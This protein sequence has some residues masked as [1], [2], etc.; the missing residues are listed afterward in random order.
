[1]T[2]GG[3]RYSGL[4]RE[5][6]AS[7]FLTVWSPVSLGRWWA[8]PSNVCPQLARWGKGAVAL[9][10]FSSPLTEVLFLRVGMMNSLPVRCAPSCP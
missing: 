7:L 1:M 8:V 5:A 10:W 6:F 9:S 4:L 3:E 2:I